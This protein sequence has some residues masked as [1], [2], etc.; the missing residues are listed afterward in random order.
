MI[1]EEHH[2]I[3]GS[4]VDDII[5]RYNGK[6]GSLLSI[7]EEV[8]ENNPAK[9]LSQDIL[10]EIAL[11]TNIS[12]SQVYGVVTFYSFFNLKPQGKHSIIVC[13]GTACHTKGSKALLDEIGP[14]I[15]YKRTNEDSESLYTTPDNLFTIKTVAC[16]GQCA[17][18][19]VVSINGTIYSNVNA[20]RL[21]VLIKK[22]KGG[23]K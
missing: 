8:Q 20:Q 15:G 5:A 19:P 12:L 9:Y 14:I 6:P 7:L 11:K 13:R 17:L 3:S 4:Q 21:K 2:T 1:G 10:R 16:F 23:K 18:S 22:L